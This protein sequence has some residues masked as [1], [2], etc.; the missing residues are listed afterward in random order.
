MLIYVA[1]A[2]IAALMRRNENTH[3]NS[4]SAHHIERLLSENERSWHITNL[5]AERPK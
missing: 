3:R 2:R 4:T 5:Q 1:S